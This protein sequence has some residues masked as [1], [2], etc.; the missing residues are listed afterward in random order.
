[1]TPSSRGFYFPAEWYP[2][3]AIWL[4]APHNTETWPDVSLIW[5]GYIKFIETIALDQIVCIQVNDLKH[6]N[7][8][9]KRLK[10]FNVSLKNIEFFLH[11]TNDSWC[12]DHGPSFIINREGQKE[13]L[14]WEYNGWGEK[15]PPFDFDNNIPNQIAKALNLNQT[16]INM[17]LEGGS[18][19][20]NGEGT[21][22]TTE[23]VLL[24]ENRNPQMSR[25]E[26]E[27]HLKE[28][29]GVTQVV[30]LKNGIE[31]DD[32]DG[33]V[34]DISRFTDESTIIT[35]VEKNIDDPNHI[36]LQ[37]N[38]ETLKQTKLANGKPLKIIEIPMPHS[39]LKNGTRLPG[40][41][42]NFLIVNKK[43][44]VPIFNCVEDKPALAIL[45]KCFPKHQVIGIDS[46]E[47]IWGRG[48][49]HCLSQQ[50]PL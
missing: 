16:N 22:L 9:E 30:W 14:N 28:N 47:I 18:V 7:Q 43:V 37:E 26:I 50:E 42:A 27:I 1:M 40:S 46:S 6:Q 11:P 15:Y 35:M 4:S 10:A 24:N 13:I 17:I 20:F 2:Q 45:S 19:D 12:R 44:I 33:H 31:G 48:S 38:F 39:I 5:P 41:Y 29:F 25:E 3:R 36:T 8:F 32:T 23:C 49:F 34:D 21:V